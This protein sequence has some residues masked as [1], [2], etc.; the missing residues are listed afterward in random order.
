[1]DPLVSELVARGVLD[2]QTLDIAR[3]Y[4][5]E[6]A[7]TLD[8][9]LLDLAFVDEEELL[10][11]LEAAYQMKA[12]RASDIA[13]ANPETAKHLPQAAAK[14]FGICPLC[15]EGNEL[16]CLVNSPLPDE[17]L[18]ELRDLFG[19]V[20]RPV[21]SPDYYLEL[22]RAVVYGIS[23]SPFARD[24]EAR[25]AR[26]RHADVR[27]TLEV[28]AASSSSAAIEQVIEFARQ[29][30]E[31]SCF[32]VFKNQRLRVAATSRGQPAVGTELPL[33]EPDC[34]LR[35][36]ILHGG[37]YVGMLPASKGAKSFYD[38]LQRPLP[39]WAFAAPVP[40]TGSATLVFCADN[41]ARG[42]A[43]RTVAELTLLVARLG[44]R[45]GFDGG[46]RTSHERP[47][48]RAPHKP[49]AIDPRPLQTPSNEPR[50]IAAGGSIEGAG[51]VA[52]APAETKSSAIGEPSLAQP[53]TA[54]E[55][56]VLARLREAAK[57]AN[58]TLAAF[59]DGLLRPAAEPRPDP[60]TTL[61]LEMK[62][63]F[64]KLAS[65][66]PAHFARGIENAFR[67]LTPRLATTT[68]A[69]TPASA[70]IQPTVAAAGVDL[71]QKPSPREVPDYNSRRRKSPRVKL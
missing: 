43:P 3:A 9:A 29:V 11:S 40:S 17:S 27:R 7:V 62:G 42:I 20:A 68:P 32:L 52:D 65:D 71:V 37:Y 63:L 67:D 69:S 41:G 18:Q 54:E 70:E 59:V 50:P 13:R 1:M 8:S 24:L 15:F 22:V 46:R 25:L 60:A 38:S 53:L 28:L 48:E 35:P 57:R 58:M 33:P 6:H 26:R 36:A 21:L 12:A 30:V 61:V 4:Q 51:R 10:S 14:S 49:S 23:A 45:G 16:V 39:R 56:L 31:F 44:A 34:P 66:I 64:D 5:V 2:R 55:A 19:I 47:V